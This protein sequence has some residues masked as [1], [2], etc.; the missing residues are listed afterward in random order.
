MSAISSMTKICNDIEVCHPSP[1]NGNGKPL[2]K[3]SGA[4]TGKVYHHFVIVAKEITVKGK[5]SFHVNCFILVV[6]S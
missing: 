6:L 5:I 4:S 3:V 1:T 2:Y